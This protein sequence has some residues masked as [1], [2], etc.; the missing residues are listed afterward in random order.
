[1]F[2]SCLDKSALLSYSSHLLVSYSSHLKGLANMSNRSTQVLIALT[3]AASAA[4]LTL[5][6]PVAGQAPAYR[7]PRLADGHPDMNGLWQALNEANFDLEA[8]DAR[9]AMALRSG[10]YGPVPAAP[11]LALGAVGAVP[12]SLGAVEGGAI[13]YK[14]EAA[15]KKKENQEHWLERDPEIKC[16]LPGVPRATYMPYP[17][18][19]LQSTKAFFIAYEYA[20]AARNIYLKDPGP[21]PVD[22][23]MGQSVGRWEGDTFVVEASSFVDQSW[24]DRAGDFHSDALKVTERYARTSPDILQYEATI[25]DPNVFTRPWK[26]SMP[27]H[28]RVEKGAQLLEFKCVEF[29]EE[30]LY[31]QWRKNPLSR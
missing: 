7:A 6:I 23:W 28:R 11:V 3:S 10:P 27:L 2:P 12:G 19:I 5:T 14:P 29:V 20:G 22:S 21:A 30:L 13:P 25:E 15:A 31:G 9:P 1:L 26:I 4:I 17:F 16:Y 8:H 18:Q 24:F